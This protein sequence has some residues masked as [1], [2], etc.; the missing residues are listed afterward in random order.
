MWQDEYFLIID[1]RVQKHTMKGMILRRN[2]TMLYEM[3]QKV[4]IEHINSYLTK[5]SIIN[6]I[7]VC[8]ICKEEKNK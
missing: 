3:D 1:R 2:A 7:E 6:L 4:G 5:S 8:N